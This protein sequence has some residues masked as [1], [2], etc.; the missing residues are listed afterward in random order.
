[1]YDYGLG[2]FNFTFLKA[3]YL[4]VNF[5][6]TFNTTNYINET[7]GI[8]GAKVLVNIYDIDDFSLID[9]STTT[10]T[11]IGNSFNKIFT[12]STG[13]YNISSLEMEEE[14]YTIIFSNPNYETTS[15]SFNYDNQQT[16]TINAYMTPISTNTTSV[17]DLLINVI[18]DYQIPMEDINVY[19]YIWDNTQGMYV[20]SNIKQTDYNG[21]TSFSVFLNTKVYN[22]CAEYNGELYCKNDK[23]INVN[24]QSITIQIP[25]SQI[26]VVN[27]SSIYSLNFSHS[28]TNTTIGNYSSVNFV[29]N[30]PNLNADNYCLNVYQIINLK[31]TSVYSNCSTS[32]NGGLNVLVNL[33]TNNSYIAI[34][35]A[36]FSGTTRETR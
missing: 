32:H 20:Q 29:W 35:S 22:F 33:N 27:V 26:D 28:L 13:L 11:F 7:Y 2:T 1:M 31:R 9:N 23:I 21:E 3:D 5:S 18:D 6:L 17:A 36:T 10:I 12:T 4:A 14:T 34:S 15:Q 8:N 19:Q 16:I 24:T 30:N 25:V